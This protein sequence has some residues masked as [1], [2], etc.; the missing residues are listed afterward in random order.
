MPVLTV[1]TEQGNALQT[2]PDFVALKRDA[3]DDLTD[4]LRPGV[5]HCRL[6]FRSELPGSDAYLIDSARW[7]AFELEGVHET[8]TVPQEPDDL[9]HDDRLDFTRRHPIIP[10]RLIVR[11]TCRRLLA[12][13]VPVA[14]AA[15]HRVC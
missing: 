6:E 15:L 5:R 13:I 1:P 8:R 2:A 9:A 7:R 11:A 12:G 10:D 4:H 14:L 3:L